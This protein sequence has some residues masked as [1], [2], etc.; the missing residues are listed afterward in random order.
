MK[1]Q[2]TQLL[3]KRLAARYGFPKQ[4][5]YANHHKRKRTSLLVPASKNSTTEKCDARSGRTTVPTARRL[6]RTKRQR[7]TATSRPRGQRNNALPRRDQSISNHGAALSN[8]HQHRRYREPRSPLSARVSLATLNDRHRGSNRCLQDSFLQ[9]SGID[10][11]M[12]TTR[13]GT[14][15]HRET[16][17]PKS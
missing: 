12:C 13:D 3:R 6:Y 17:P 10:R 11:L 5:F 14:N 15:R 9:A 7:D 4:S 8:L 1:R 2:G 16:A